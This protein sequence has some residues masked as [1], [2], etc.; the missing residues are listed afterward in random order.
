MSLLI[1]FLTFKRFIFYGFPVYLVLADFAMRFLINFAPGRHE[2]I[3]IVA[4]S[5]SVAAAGLALIAPVLIPKPLKGEIS[6]SAQTEIQAIEG[7]LVNG[8]DQSLIS[9]A[10]VGL[11]LLPFLWGTS[12]W[13]AHDSMGQHVISLGGYSI[14][15]P[16]VI[17]AVIYAIAMLYTER[18]DAV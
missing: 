7:K 2:E 8:K 10:Y 12:L 9:L 6:A 14:P 13:L 17:A 15:T 11:L 4:A 3:S 1:K 18:K 5:N 16:A